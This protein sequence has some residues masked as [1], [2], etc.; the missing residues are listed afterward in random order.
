MFQCGDWGYCCDGLQCT[1]TTLEQDTDNYVFERF[2][3]GNASKS[4]NENVQ[5]LTKFIEKF[6]RDG[7]I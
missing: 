1:D 4:Y 7:F 6:E 5:G 2:F 3:C